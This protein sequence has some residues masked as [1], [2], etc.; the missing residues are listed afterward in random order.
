MNYFDTR[1]T[2]V[3]DPV[4]LLFVPVNA[5]SS[6]VRLDLSFPLESVQDLE[7]AN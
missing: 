7:R 1:H 5:S 3:F 6:L 4:R 2:T